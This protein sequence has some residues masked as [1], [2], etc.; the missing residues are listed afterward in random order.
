MARFKVTHEM[1]SRGMKGAV[2]GGK[3]TAG[4]TRHYKFRTTSLYRETDKR[5]CDVTPESS[6]I[7]IPE[8]DEESL[9]K[10][11]PQACVAYDRFLRYW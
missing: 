4:N 6:N 2:A 11:L 1:E 7:K 5:G 9:L 10:S 3:T 8:I